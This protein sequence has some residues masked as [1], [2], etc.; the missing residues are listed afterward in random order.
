MVVWLAPLLIIITS[1]IIGRLIVALFVPRGLQRTDWLAYSFACMALG[2]GILSWIAVVLAEI[3]AYSIFLLGIIWLVLVVLLAFFYFRKRKLSATDGQP[4]NNEL[5]DSEAT[6]GWSLKRWVQPLI[7]GGWLLAAGWLFFRPHQYVNGAADAG[8]YVNLAANIHNAGSIVYEDSSLAE[9][10]PSLYDVFLRALPE[11]K[12]LPQAASSYLF[13]GFYVT[14]ADAGQI[15]P[16]FFPLHA[17]WQAFAYGIGDVDAVLLMTG[18]WALLG[19]LAIYLTARELAGWPTAAIALIGVTLNALQIWFARYPTTEA[20]T[21]FLLWTSI[22]ALLVWIRRIKRSE[23]RTR[24][25]LS[26][27][28]WALL[29][30]VMMGELFLVRIDTYFLLVIPI[31]IWFWLRTTGHWRRNDWWFFGAVGLLALHSLV[32]ANWLSRPYFYNIFGYGLVLV[33]RFWPFFLIL[34]LAGG[35]LMASSAFFQHR[36]VI[37]GRR[38]RQI[39][40]FAAVLVIVI[41]AYNWFIRP[42]IGGGDFLAEYWYGGGDIPR[43]LDRENLVRLGWYL[44]PVGIL[45]ATAGT[46]L[47][48]LKLDLRK[49][50]VLV[51]GLS[52]SALYIWKI[53]ANP[54]QI[55][56]MRRYVPVVMPFAIIASA[57]FLGWIILKK[58][59]WIKI[60]GAV[61]AVIWMVGLTWSARGFISQ[62]DYVNLQDQIGQIDTLLSPESV[63]IFDDQSAITTGDIIGTPLHFLY[64]HDVYSIRSPEDLDQDALTNAINHWRQVGRDVY[65]VG[66]PD[67]AQ[68]LGLVATPL[69]D[70][71]IKTQQLEGSY[72]RK[73]VA[74]LDATWSLNISLIEVAQQ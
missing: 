42:R 3:G 17:I 14:D 47:L 2:I 52:F 65:W 61:L 45:L 34:A 9:L 49:G 38:R 33:E 8:V 7:L 28:F 69:E 53:Q 31:I 5:V 21:Q 1:F 70:V 68:L 35:V 24:E 20:L 16:Q 37:S 57:Y 32:H 22:W 62:I 74:I 36:I 60:G 25:F 41:V 23:D 15:V 46:C 50:L 13:P 51:A 19:S 67:T 4:G 40:A 26:R 6:T 55:Y 66:L 56:A 12:A 63:L 73:P 27:P 64:G 10:Q 58:E 43:N 18:F 71:T 39:L 48:I 11:N 30:G 54:H 29:A 59:V 44:S 72:D